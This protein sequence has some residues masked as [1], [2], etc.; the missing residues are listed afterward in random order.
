MADQGAGGIED[1]LGFLA[2][3][4]VGT[5]D[6]FLGREVELLAEE[7]A[8]CGGVRNESYS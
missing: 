2:R 6:R 3:V 7:E 8:M 5:E 4:P 1:L